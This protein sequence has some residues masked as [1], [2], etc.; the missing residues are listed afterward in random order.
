MGTICPMSHMVQPIQSVWAYDESSRTIVCKLGEIMRL[1]FCF[2]GLAICNGIAQAED[3]PQWLGPKRDGVW[4]ATGIIDS[5]SKEGAKVVWRVPLG[6][7][8]SGPAVANGK[9]FVMDRVLDEGVSLPPN[10]FSKGKNKGKG[11]IKEKGRIEE[12]KK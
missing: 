7:G 10:A 9:V 12:K 4:S 11:G 5:F 1:F 2:A 8:Y 3:W 6:M